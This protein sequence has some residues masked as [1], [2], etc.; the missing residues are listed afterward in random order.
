MNRANAIGLLAN[1]WNR[2]GAGEKKTE[3]IAMAM[4]RTIAYIRDGFRGGALIQER[5][6][7]LFDSIEEKAITFGKLLLL[8]CGAI[9]LVLVLK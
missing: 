7:G 1:G 5:V 9:L 4:G 2:G 6:S 3:N 8:I